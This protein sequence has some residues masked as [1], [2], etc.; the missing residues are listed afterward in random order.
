MRRFER[1]SALVTTTSFSADGKT[2]LSGSMDATLRLWDV[3]T[4]DEIWRFIGHGRAVWSASFSADGRY[5]ISGE[6]DG[7]II[8]WDLKTGDIVRSFEGQG[9]MGITTSAYG[10]VRVWRLTLGLNDLLNWTSS[11]RY[12]RDLACSE[13]ELYHVLSRCSG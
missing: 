9:A 11:H 12:V 2:I 6:Q 1:H 8:V 7:T 3:V 4:G 5:A 10:M 13:R